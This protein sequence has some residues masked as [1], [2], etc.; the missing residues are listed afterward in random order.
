MFAAGALAALWSADRVWALVGF[1]GVV[2]QNAVFSV[3]IALRLA[4][5]GEGATG[6]LWRLHDVLIA[7]NGTFL[8]LA[9]VGF[10]LGGRRAGLVRRWHAAVG[11]TGAA[12]LFAGATLAPWVTAEQGPLSL[13]GL[14]GWL[15]WAVWLGV[16]GVTLL[17]GRITAASPVAA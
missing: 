16:Y 15:L 1:A 13:V 6:G 12:L 7:F 5:A 2:L 10:T 11:L 17:R 14:A 9:L 3:V 4:L 8:A